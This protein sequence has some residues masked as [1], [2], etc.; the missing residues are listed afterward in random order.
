MKSKKQSQAI[1]ET[2]EIERL[3]QVRRSLEQQFAT[4][5][6]FFDWLMRL[7]EE[8]RKKGRKFFTPRKTGTKAH[9]GSKR[10]LPKKAASGRKAS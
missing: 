10:R 3:R 9:A 4:T 1:H 5:E 7:D 2:D 8:A 6:E